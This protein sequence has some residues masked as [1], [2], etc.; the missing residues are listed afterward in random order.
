MHI[1]DHRVEVASE[2]FREAGQVF[3]A[4]VFLGPIVDGSIH[5]F[6]VAFG[7]GIAFFLWF[8]SMIIIK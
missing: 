8:L 7:I 5:P 1:S 2:I 4:T 3:F 6:P